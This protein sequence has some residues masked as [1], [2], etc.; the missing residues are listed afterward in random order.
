MAKRPQ[1]HHEL[2]YQDVILSLLVATKPPVLVRFLGYCLHAYISVRGV[3]YTT[4][5]PLLDY[6]FGTALGAQ[7]FIGIYLLWLTSPVDEF[8]HER[9]VLPPREMSLWRRLYWASTACLSSRGVGWNFQV[10]NLPPRPRE[11]RWAFVRSRLLRIAWYFVMIDMSE[12]YMRLNKIFVS[13]GIYA[14]RSISSQG[15]L[16]RCASIIVY[17]ARL[18]GLLAL[19]F[20]IPAV[21]VVALGIH[22][23]AD[24]PDAFGSWKDCYTVRNFWGKTWHQTLRRF[25]TPIGR[26][27][28]RLFGFKKGTTG[29][30]YT[31]LYVAF[32]VSGLM[33]C[34]GDAMVGW[35]YFGSSMPFF[36]LQALAITAEGGVIAFYRK[37]GVQLSP[38]LARLIGY[39]WVFVWFSFSCPIYIDWSLK[40][41]VGRSK[42][43]PISL[44]RYL[45]RAYYHL[46]FREHALV[47]LL[48]KFIYD[49]NNETQWGDIHVL[50]YWDSNTDLVNT[51]KDVPEN[52]REGE[53]AEK[54]DKMWTEKPSRRLPINNPDNAAFPPQNIVR[55]EISLCKNSSPRSTN[56]FIEVLETLRILFDMVANVVVTEEPIELIDTVKR[57]PFV[58]VQSAVDASATINSLQF[59]WI[60]RAQSTKLVDIALELK[61]RARSLLIS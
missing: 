31:Q 44:V 6:T 43:L 37:S 26:F 24:W 9:D 10:T 25:T 57:A 39:A 21:I 14:R 16:L 56:I 11:S 23:P 2:I 54:E 22:K 5:D 53:Q 8:R 40:A 29:S 19:Q 35:K 42:L 48:A 45:L 52:I 17:W 51:R 3:S 58:G 28:V 55:P 46:S 30:S 47:S 4:G 38:T 15:Y 59:H 32:I 33:H 1:L 7:I 41:G 20:S 50:Y 34:A 18:Y 12:T 27:F 60:W 49:R 36:I 13:R 61:H